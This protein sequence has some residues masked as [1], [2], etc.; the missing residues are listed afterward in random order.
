M[1]LLVDVNVLVAA[2]RA[3]HP[4]H[5]RALATLDGIGRD[6]FALCAHTWNGF[7]RLV[8][9]PKV[10]PDP[11]PLPT[12]LAAVAAWR[13]RPRS[14]VLADTPTS[15]EAFARLCR[16]HQATGNALYDLHLAALAIAYDCALLSSDQ[17]FARVSGLRWIDPGR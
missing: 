13:D 5:A 14:A 10:F 11:T 4:Q 17:G 16:Q 1:S 12:A 6:G 8:T 3:D 9:H 15:W 2:H 7:L